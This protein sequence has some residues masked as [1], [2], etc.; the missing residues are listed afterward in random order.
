MSV[1]TLERPPTLALTF[2][3]SLIFEHPLSERVRTW[4]RLEEQFSRMHAHT[5]RRDAMDHRDALVGL[6]D[7]IDT[8]T[9]SDIKTD[10]LAELERQRA[11]WTAQLGNPD[12]AREALEEFLA[13]VDTVIH[14]LHAQLGKIGQHLRDSEWLQAVRQ[15]ESSPGG[16]C[17]FELPMLMSWL[18]RSEYERKDTLKTWLAPLVPL[19]EAVILILR[20]LRESSQSTNELARQGNFHRA[21]VNARPPMLATI[22]VEAG[23][24]VVSE[25]SANKYTVNVRFLEHA[26]Q[27]ASASR[28]LP[29]QRNVP[30]RLGLCSL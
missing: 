26:G 3:N 19:E 16:A 18:Q 11:I 15:R 21:L 2:E 14:E 30:F 13:D 10:L 7:L 29:T 6:F 28:A 12:V 22:E 17:V 5:A 20:L 24:H 23:E 4:L 8:A 25:V 27:F 9:R 1:H